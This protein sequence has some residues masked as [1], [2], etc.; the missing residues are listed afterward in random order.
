MKLLAR[1]SIVEL[2]QLKRPGGRF[3]SRSQRREPVN[4]S[5]RSTTTAAPPRQN[6]VLPLIEVIDRAA[7][8]YYDEHPGNDTKRG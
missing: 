1:S 4:V 3:A 2:S 5:F 7:Q 6:I 8:L